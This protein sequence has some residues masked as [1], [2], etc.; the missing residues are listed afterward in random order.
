MQGRPS[1]VMLY[2]SADSDDGAGGGAE[3]F[4]AWIAVSS[5]DGFH[6]TI[7]ISPVCTICNELAMPVHMKIRHAG[8]EEEYPAEIQPGA[9]WEVH[10]FHP[11]DS[12]FLW[13]KLPGFH[14]SKRA[15]IQ[16]D[17]MVPRPTSL[18]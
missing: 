7:K 18:I 10:S 2:D 1:R 9:S 8:G 14:W 11:N 15:R 5:A 17:P 3:R 13:A 12:V 16:S 4:R 6:I